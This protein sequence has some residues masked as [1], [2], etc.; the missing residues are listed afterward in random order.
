MILFIR[1]YMIKNS[2]LA[3]TI[4]VVL[5]SLAG[6]ED[7]A[8]YPVGDN[9]YSLVSTSSSEGSAQNAAVYKAT[10]LCQKQ[11]K[12]LKVLSHDSTYQGV[13]KSHKAMINLAGSMLSGKP[14]SANSG[15]DYKVNLKFKCV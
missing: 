6:C 7:P 8:V 2:L 12:H 11:G 15:D 5:V 4:I 10:K 13:D 1:V 9:T 14:Y 3:A